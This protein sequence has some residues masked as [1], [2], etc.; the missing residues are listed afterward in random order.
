MCNTFWV[1]LLPE[2]VKIESESRP[3]LRA[4]HRKNLQS[5]SDYFLSAQWILY[6]FA[7]WLTGGRAASAAA[8]QSNVLAQ[9]KTNSSIEAA[10]AVHEWPLGQVCQVGHL[11]KHLFRRNLVS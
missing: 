3:T 9:R 10:L 2:K 11:T 8:G 1:P 6:H 7:H 4:E 5:D